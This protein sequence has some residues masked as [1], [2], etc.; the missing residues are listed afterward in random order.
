[1]SL[2]AYYVE[3]INSPLPCRFYEFSEF[4]IAIFDNFESVCLHAMDRPDKR[5]PLTPEL[6]GSLI[7]FYKLGFSFAE[8]AQELDIHVSHSS[9]YFLLLTLSFNY[10]FILEKKNIEQSPKS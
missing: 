10:F 4:F 5:K 8:I 7:T 2:N 6:K 9:M 1:M 3:E